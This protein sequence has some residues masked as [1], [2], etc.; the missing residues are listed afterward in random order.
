MVFING[1]KYAC[2]TCIKGHRSTACHHSERPL[3]VIK[4][5]GRPITQCAHCRELR[6]TQ[7]VHVK[8]TCNEKKKDGDFHLTMNLPTRGIISPNCTSNG[9]L[10]PQ[11]KME[12]NFMELNRQN[13]LED[14]HSVEALLNPCQCSTGAK[15][16]CCRP[17][18]QNSN[19][20]A[21]ASN[22]QFTSNQSQIY[23][24]I[25]RMYAATTTIAGTTGPNPNQNNLI[26]LLRIT[27]PN[28]SSSS[29]SPSNT[30]FSSIASQ[31]FG[32]VP[33]SV[34]PQTTF[35][36]PQNSINS[37]DYDP[38]KINPI[39]VSQGAITASAWNGY[40]SDD[41]I[42]TSLPGSTN[43]YHEIRQPRTNTNGHRRIASYPSIL[44]PSPKLESPSSF[45]LQSYTSYQEEDE[46]SMTDEN[47][48]LGEQL[49]HT[50]A[51]D[52]VNII[53]SS[54]QN[55]PP[56]MPS[57]SCCAPANST[58]VSTCHCGIGCGCQGCNT[59]EQRVS[60][61]RGYE[62][63]NPYQ[64]QTDL[65]NANILNRR[66]NCCSSSQAIVQ[67]EHSIIIDEDGVMV[68]GC[69]CRKPNTECSDCIKNLCE[70]Y[71]LKQPPI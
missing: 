8:C 36:S 57:E 30:P 12:G 26:S 2:A 64:I 40:S 52:L 65:R 53:Y 66:E 31:I 13:D 41:G 4:R 50:S 71:L 10:D 28:S 14:K 18:E 68:C 1:V 59:H 5:K 69:G 23:D 6:K 33:M 58:S 9:G 24:D 42:S 62:S 49:C 34:I 43:T 51:D 39:N 56:S 11:F 19:V 60:G 37:S 17:V 61:A 27:S 44:Y 70:E 29:I 46:K 38:N 48:V 67:Q 16:I 20:S 21:I 32:Q 54:F 47:S 25:N 55:C 35:S 45:Q 3:F 15:C 7:K 63:V 22:F